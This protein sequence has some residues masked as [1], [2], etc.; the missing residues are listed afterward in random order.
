MQYEIVC[1]GNGTESCW[2]WQAIMTLNGVRVRVL[3][4]FPNKAHPVLEGATKDCIHIMN[5]CQNVD[6]LSHKD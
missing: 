4:V 6:G 2:E 5:V 1:D 3:E